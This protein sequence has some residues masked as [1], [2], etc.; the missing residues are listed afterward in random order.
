ML[1]RFVLILAIGML[2][3]AGLA[4]RATLHTVFDG[5]TI[6]VLDENGRSIRVRLSG[7]DAPERG[8]PYGLKASESL[9]RLLSGGAL[10]VEAHSIDRYQRVLAKVTCAGRDA[11]L[12]Q[13]R[14]GSAW[15]YP[16]TDSISQSDRFRYSREEQEARSQHRGLWI[17]RDAV[18]PWQFRR[19]EAASWPESLAAHSPPAVALPYSSARVVVLPPDAS[20]A[21]KTDSAKPVTH[22]AARH[23]GG[24]KK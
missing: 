10:D 15:F 6:D 14:S 24:K 4:F 22:K 20:A 12:E 11:G 8:Q 18:P 16:W 23:P 2:P 17:D 7:I 13:I 5:D 1:K 19:A 21:L 3:A 9:R